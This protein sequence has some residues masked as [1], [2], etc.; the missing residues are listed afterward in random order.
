M[1]WTDLCNCGHRH[2][3][4]VN[5]W[6]EGEFKYVSIQAKCDVPG[7]SCEAFHHVSLR[8]EAWKDNGPP[9]HRKLKLKRPTITERR[10]R[11]DGMGRNN[12]I[13]T[14]ANIWGLLDG[15]EW[16]PDTF[17]EI[18]GELREAGLPLRQPEEYDDA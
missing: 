2:R 8:V 4:Q 6:K 7:C 18:A 12:M 14:L 15:F 9:E 1:S 17:D 11:V 10:N 5:P 3:W 13:R 16:T